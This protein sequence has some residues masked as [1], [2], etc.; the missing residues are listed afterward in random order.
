MVNKQN[1]VMQVIV[2]SHAVSVQAIINITSVQV[3]YCSVT[4]NLLLRL[5]AR[6][7]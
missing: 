6:T 2:G 5:F 3:V 7:Y 4:V 1:I